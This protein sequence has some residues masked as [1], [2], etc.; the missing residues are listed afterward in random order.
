MTIDIIKL[1]KDLYEK[2]TAF[3]NQIKQED[4]AHILKI[5]VQTFKNIEKGKSQDYRMSTI[6]NIVE[7][8]DTEIGKYIIK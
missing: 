1:G 7:F 6:L 3:H 2:R 5:S 8:L 4:L